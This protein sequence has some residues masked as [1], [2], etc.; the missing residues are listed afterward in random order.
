VC[1][2]SFVEVKKALK[3]NAPEDEV[4]PSCNASSIIKEKHAAVTKVTP[5]RPRFRL[6]SI[7]NH[8]G[9]FCLQ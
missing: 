1:S 5:H 4:P 8:R 2:S 3:Q 6:T 7:M 9:L